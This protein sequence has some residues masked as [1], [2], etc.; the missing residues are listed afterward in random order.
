MTDLEYAALHGSSGTSAARVAVPGVA[1]PPETATAEE[2]VSWAHRVHGDALAL[3]SSFGADAAL[4]LHLVTRIV[5]DVKVIFVDTGYLFRE[6][7]RF[8][9]ELTQRFSLNLH[10]YGPKITPARQEALYGQLWEQGEVGVRRYL[11]LNKVEPMQRAL[12]DLGITG[13]LAGLR[14]GQTEHRKTLPRIA[15]QDGRMKVHPILGWDKQQVESYFEEHDLPRHPLYAKG[16]RSIG[17]VHS[18]LPV[19]ADDDDRA[20]RFLGAKKEC[21]LHLS[22]EE[23]TSLSS[24]GL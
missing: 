19:S 20:G 18:T 5:P 1:E 11:L 10:V 23:N 9:E 17:D 24:S 3:S 12:S 4:M 14:A 2:L 21:G 16:Y 8:A 13:W 6:T 7:Y 22:A 15:Q